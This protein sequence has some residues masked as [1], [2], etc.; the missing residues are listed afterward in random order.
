MNIRFLRSTFDY[1]Y[2][3]DYETCH[4]SHHFAFTLCAYRP[5]VG[6]LRDLC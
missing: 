3:P 6:E 4:Y 5:T 2:T 1:P